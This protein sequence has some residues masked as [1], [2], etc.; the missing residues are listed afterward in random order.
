MNLKQEKNFMIID[1]H[2]HIGKWSEVFFNY[3]ST[4]EQAIYVMKSSGVDAAV[5]MPTDSTSNLEL[6]AQTIDNRDFK[7]YYMAWINPMDPELDKFLENNINRISLFKIHPSLQKRRI[8]DPSFVKYLALA[9]SRRIPVVVHC[10]RWQEIA[11]YKFCL[12][13]SVMFPGIPL[14]LAHMG[15]DQ[16]GLIMECAIEIARNRYNNVY[17]GTESVREFYFVNNAVKIVGADKVIFGSDYNL[18]LPSMYI[19]LI[20]SL[21]IP[22]TDKEQIFSGNILRLISN[23]S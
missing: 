14:I 19:P 17:L 10:G 9:E 13:V 2:I 22:A 6:F 20:E 15:G 11:S 16:P 4:V 21:D 12:E 23:R 5:C 8:T 7:F 1:S 3:T 18:G